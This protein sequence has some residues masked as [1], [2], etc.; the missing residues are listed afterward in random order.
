MGVLKFFDET[1]EYEYQ[2]VVIPSVSEIIHFMSREVYGDINRYVLDR[3]AE[4][5]TSVHAATQEIDAVGMCEIE[6]H[7][8]GYITAYANFI[9]KVHPKWI[10]IEKA[11]A[12]P[13]MRFAGTP[14][15]CGYIHGRRAILDIKTNAAIKKPLVKAQL[16][17][18]RRL[19]TANRFRTEVL[20][21]LQLLPTGRY[22]LYP[23]TLDYTEFMACYQLHQALSKKSKR[24]AIE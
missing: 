10:H 14:D 21:C 6:T 4:R 16:N 1:H 17:G 3:A 11:F 24:G 15:R 9:S 7:L 23:V 2:G 18:Y 22:R 20:Y 12:H 13:K 19:M 5:G 8:S